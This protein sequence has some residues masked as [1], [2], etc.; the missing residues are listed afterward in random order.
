MRL[1]LLLTFV[2]WGYVQFLHAAPQVDSVVNQIAETLNGDTIENRRE[3]MK[4]LLKEVPTDTSTQQI[5]ADNDT[6]F[7]YKY[8]DDKEFDYYRRSGSTSVWDT[9]MNALE[10]ILR[11]ILGYAPDSPFPNYTNLVVKILSA[12][13]II[14]VL[15]FI[16]R[17]TV[18]HKG[19]WFFAEKNKELPLDI[20][21]V[22]NLIKSADFENLISET[23]A[24]GDTRLSIR[25][26][27]LWLLKLLKYKEI[28]QWLPDKTNSEY[29]NEIQDQAIREDFAYLS[30]LYEYIWYGEFLVSD[31]DY[32][33]AKKY[34]INF[35]NKEAKHG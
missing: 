20:Y 32:Q 31:T 24:R 1:K 10:R 18:N 29:L 8:L 5:V 2:V 14:I 17:L 33:K 25:L 30:Y 34:F 7:R 13:V 26:Y 15:Y 11:K 27:Y 28:I 4:K 21:D 3:A 16:V 22:E 19:S 35:L 6:T 23:E 12:I 9:I